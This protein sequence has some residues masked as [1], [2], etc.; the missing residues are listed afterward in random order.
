MDG[1]PLEEY[2]AFLVDGS[3]SIAHPTCSKWQSVGTVYSAKTRSPLVQIMRIEGQ[4]FATK[5]AAK[6]HGIE[7]AKKWVDEQK[8]GAE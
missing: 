7:L 6:R 4:S 8:P 2:N 3:I 5:E 1:S